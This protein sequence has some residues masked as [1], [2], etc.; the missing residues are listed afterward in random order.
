M[1][2]YVMLGY[3]TLTIY[4]STVGYPSDSL[5]SCR[6]IDVRRLKACFSISPLFDDNARGNEFRAGEQ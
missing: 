3:V 2:C 1:L 4:G 6:N 5:A